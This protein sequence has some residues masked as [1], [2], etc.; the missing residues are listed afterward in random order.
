MELSITSRRAQ[1]AGLEPELDGDFR[2]ERYIWTTHF[3][4]QSLLPLAL[5]DQSLNELADRGFEVFSRFEGTNIGTERELDLP[6]FIRIA[7]R[8]FHHERSENFFTIDIYF[9]E[10]AIGVG[11]RE[12]EIQ[13]LARV[14]GTITDA[15]GLSLPDETRERKYHCRSLA[16]MIRGIFVIHLIRPTDFEGLGE[17]I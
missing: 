10:R 5:P 6:H 17:P 11:R 1:V 2:Y 7:T 16:E 3:S 13:W 14:R 8:R 4:L 9:S 12:V 15:Q